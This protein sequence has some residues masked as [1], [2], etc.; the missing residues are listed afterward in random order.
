MRVI[1]GQTDASP[2]LQLWTRHR[3]G[4]GSAA[5][6]MASSCPTKYEFSVVFVAVAVSFDV[7]AIFSVCPWHLKRMFDLL[8]VLAAVQL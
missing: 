5:A 1:V 8:R 7:A 6:E 4:D 3:P 2:P